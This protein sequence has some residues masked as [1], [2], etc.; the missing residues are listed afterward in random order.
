M[1]WRQAGRWLRGLLP[2]YALVG[3]MWAA[4]TQVPRLNVL[5]LG[6]FTLLLALP[7]MLALWH[8]G[9]VRRL[10]SL[11]QFQP[12]RG[13]HRW[14]SR[15][16][17]GLLWRAALAIGLSAAVL[18]QTVFFGRLEWLLLC[19][20]PLLYLLTR[21]R[22]DA[23]T[24][25]QFTQPIFGQRW[26]LQATQWLVTLLLTVTWVGARIWLAEA[27]SLP[28]AERIHA[29]QSAW[30]SAPSGLVKWALDAGA[31]GQATVEALD[32]RAAQSWW[33]LLLTL[34][35]APVS[36]L[37]HLSLS[38]S[39]LALPLA[40]VRRS[41]GQRL[42]ADPAPPPIG[43]ARAALWAAV[44][45]ILV[46]MLFQFLGAIDHRLR[47]TDSPLAIQPVPPCERI[48]GKVYALNTSAALTA[49][50]D[51]ASGRI[52][53]HQA[54]ACATLG[55]VEALASQGVEQYLDWY[56]SLGA[57]WSRFA[58]LLTGDIDLL[59]AAK[60]SQMVMSRPEIVQRLPVV[61]A[62]Y[63]AQW[64]QVVAA[65]S[66]ALDL[67]DQNRL[68]LDE[69]GCK[70]ISETS[71]AP[72]SAHW[73]ASQARLV[74]GS[75]AGLIAGALAAKATA[76]AMSK[77]AVKSASSVLAKL[78][79]KK[80]IGKAGAAAVGAT[81]GTMVAPG[82][83]TAVGALIGA[84]VGLAVGVGVD[85]AALAAEEKLTREDMRKDLLS[86]VSE[87]LQ[88]YRDTFDCQSA[89]KSAGQGTK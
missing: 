52:A 34:V 78:M 59:L 77:A 4:S 31:W 7:M 1:A 29:L 73:Q 41:L 82:L 51:A 22:L 24:A 80:A 30:A 56:F 74:G 57:E 26:S 2:G 54:T 58:T 66:L 49:L 20:A 72:G 84:G 47:K 42:T 46:L 60:F 65:R 27:P 16:A 45:S 79:A 87:S 85:L 67:L 25:A 23:L 11:H 68:V 12:G 40:E 81:V 43:A 33:R 3:L 8:Q 19:L 76:K 75:G 88:P 18:L 13:L 15:R 28:Y 38:L 39:G 83:G 61:Q 63:E 21:E 69:R 48:D 37:G 89:G 64:A 50:L 14:G 36:V 44:A 62:A 9:T 5:W 70:V 35:V 32:H 53:G 55:E 86:A 6:T 17:L 71:A 10:M